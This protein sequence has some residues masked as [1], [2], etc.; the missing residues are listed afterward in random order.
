MPINIYSVPFLENYIFWFL[1]RLLTNLSMK[2]TFGHDIF[3]E[4]VIT[5][6]LFSLTLSHSIPSWLSLGRAVH[7]LCPNLSIYQFQKLLGKADNRQAELTILIYIYCILGSY[8]QRHLW[9]ETYTILKYKHQGLF[10]GQGNQSIG[11]PR[12]I[13]RSCY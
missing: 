10:L 5:Q 8:I 11:V 3:I 13:I 4:K 9:L 2:I 7:V 6:L 1:L 12:K